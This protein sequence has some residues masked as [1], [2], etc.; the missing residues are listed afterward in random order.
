MLTKIPSGVAR[1]SAAVSLFL[2]CLADLTGAHARDAS[3]DPPEPSIR[4]LTRAE[5]RTAL[6]EG[7]SRAYYAGLQLGEMRAKT[8]LP[9]KDLSL[10]EA[11][12]RVRQAYGE[13]APL[14][15]RTPW[16]LIKV[17]ATL[18]GGLSHTRGD[19]VILADA[20]LAQLLRAHA[21]RAFDGPSWFWNLLVHEQ[22]HVLERRVPDRF[23]NLFTRVFGFRHVILG[24]A[25]PWLL[26][27]N[28]VNPDGPV[29][30]WAFPDGE[31]AARRWLLPEI[32][33]RELDAPR[34]PEDFELVATPV[35]ARGGVWQYLDRSAPETTEPLTNFTE[36]FGKFP[37]RDELF[38]PNEIAAGLL[39]AQGSGC[40]RSEFVI[41]A[42]LRPPAL[43]HRR[44][45][46][47]AS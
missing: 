42:A 5:A 32:Q 37:I 23:A 4:F 22:T 2:L 20:L 39:A 25:P 1:A 33:L 10:A 35:Q 17:A 6:T 44:R 21:Q 46:I 34:M 45:P 47:P 40:G 8:G 36:F 14:Y 11:R 31:G 38:H 30:D 3:T 16:S 7:E 13:R 15:A 18:E 29:Q 12:E 43:Q 27:R 26:L 9:L 24:P 41:L 28:V 19:S